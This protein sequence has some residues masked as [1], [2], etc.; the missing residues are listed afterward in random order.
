VLK[1]HK[2]GLLQNLFPQEGE[3]MP[4]LRFKEFENSG[5]WRSE[6]VGN[7]FKFKQ[8]VQVPVENQ[9]ANQIEGMVRFIRIIDITNNSEP[10][11][12]I[13][14]P[15]SEHLIET[16]DLF[17]IRY[18]TPGLIS[19]G[20]EGVIANNLF[21]L[22]WKYDELFVPRF[23]LYAFQKIEKLI[24]ELSSS[25]SMPAISFSTMEGVSLLFPKNPSEQQ[26]IADTLLSSDDLINAQIQKLEALQL[27]KKG[28][29]QGL[30]PSI[31]NE[32]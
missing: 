26:K 31:N 5:E 17:M 12:Y 13:E 29:L 10:Y 11:R 18:G 8:G 4:K 1:E 3:T 2:K 16:N 28:L 22:I 30:F 9:F 6:G 20:Y 7:L 24:Y 27:H 19:I 32:E 14:S 15:S 25:S 23:W 21:R